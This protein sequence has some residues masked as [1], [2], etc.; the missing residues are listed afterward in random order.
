[1]KRIL[2]IMMLIFSCASAHASMYYK[3]EKGQHARVGMNFTAKEFKCKCCGKAI[4]DGALIYR[5]E[6]LRIKLGGKRIN[7]TSG[8]RCA[9]HN[10]AVRGAKRSQHIK[11]KAAD[12][13]VEGVSPS[14]VARY[15]KQVG[16]TFVKTYSRWTHVDVR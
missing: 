1:M 9:K 14:T 10:K 4:V 7:I 5:L 15:A 16:F 6:L 13:R 12:I 3:V 11:G 2:I 8:Y